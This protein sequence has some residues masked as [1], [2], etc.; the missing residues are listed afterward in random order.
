[1]LKILIK[2]L[3]AAVN[4]LSLEKLY[5]FKI[6]RLGNINAAEL[7]IVQRRIEKLFQFNLS[8]V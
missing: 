3:D 6:K 1:M 5:Q 7:F 8:A 2:I 4:L